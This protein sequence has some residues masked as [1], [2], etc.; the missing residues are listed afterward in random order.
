MTSL[1]LILPRT[2]PTAATLCDGLLTG[3]ASA[4]VRLVQTT[5]ALLPAP[6][7][8]TVVVVPAA[9]L[10]WHQIELPQGALKGNASRL[11]AVLDG[12][13]EERL[14]DDTAQLHLALEPQARAGQP[15]W[16]AACDRV[17]LYAWLTALEQ[18]GRPAARIVPELAP[19]AADAPVQG[20]L[21]A[22]G[23]PGNPHLLLTGPGGVNML[24]LSASAAALLAW[25]QEADLLA[26]PGVAA[27]AEDCFKRP[28]TLQSAA[29]RWLA[30]AQ[31]GWDLAQFDLLRT[32]R[33]R[34]RKQL[35][36]L[37][38][39]L[40]EAP[41]WRAA[42][43]AAIALIAINLTGLQAWAWKQESAL[44]AKRTAI[45]ETLT[46]AFPDVR[47][48][49]DAPVQMKRAL[50]DLQRRNG[51][52]SAADLETM[53]GQLQ[54]AAPDSAPPAGIEFTAGELRLKQSEPSG[55]ALTSVVA[56]LQASGYS[57]RIEGANLVMKEGRP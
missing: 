32:R 21:Q 13:L 43:W 35:A 3:D 18:A 24:P 56:R 57:A 52:A 19:P 20:S 49:V 50:T 31:S 39:E 8:E 34:T 17:W 15:V 6:G 46:A 26:E 36:T 27:L 40:L 14:L 54:A 44:A 22:V 11:R 41:R 47:V 5:L 29:D 55:A 23:N 7:L 1:I 45:R 30:A 51:A 25:P 12:L 16:I 9:Q 4:A 28:V 53:L 37:A 48:V 42:R 10:S 33:T 2:L 38:S